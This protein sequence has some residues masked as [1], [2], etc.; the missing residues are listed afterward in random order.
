MTV[1]HV[2][3]TR[4]E[5]ELAREVLGEMVGSAV[6]MQNSLKYNLAGSEARL[7]GSMLEVQV[8]EWVDASI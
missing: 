2:V 7:L 4:G 5:R 6:V 3:M 8:G 1:A